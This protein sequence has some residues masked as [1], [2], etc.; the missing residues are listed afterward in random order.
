MSSTVRVYP[1]GASVETSRVN[2][3]LTT[4][5]IVWFLMADCISSLIACGM[6]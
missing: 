1:A 5:F 3:T 2:R 4:W 6:S